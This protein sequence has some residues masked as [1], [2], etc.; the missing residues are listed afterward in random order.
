MPFPKMV[1]IRQRFPRPMITDVRGKVRET[2]MESPLPSKIRPGQRMAITAG[3]RGVANIVEVLAEVVRVVRDLGGDPFLVPA[4]GSHGGGTAEGQLAMLESLGITEGSV[5][6]PILSSMDVRQIGATPSGVPVYMDRNALSADG[7]I[8]VNRVK[9]HTAIR[10]SIQSGLCKMLMIGLGKQ[11]GAAIAHSYG[12]TAMA[13]LINDVTRIA[14]RSA[15]ILGGLALVENGY[16]ETAKI[17]AVDPETW[18]ETEEKLLEEA[19][20]MMPRLP[21]DIRAMRVRNTLHIDELEV[22]EALLREVG[23]VE[24]IDITGEPRELAFDNEGNLVKL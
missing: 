15:P 21:A 22:S 7:I 16:D 3:S 20:A 1:T 13:E 11:K 4:M 10:G 24:G 9:P 14:L 19:G 12:P 8:A 23:G 2:L 5:G 17:A 18:I 6:A